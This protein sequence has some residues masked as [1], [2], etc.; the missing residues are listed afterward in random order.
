MTFA[1]I[2]VAL[3]AFVFI[4]GQWADSHPTRHVRAGAGASKPTHRKSRL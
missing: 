1:I 2:L 3:S 4:G